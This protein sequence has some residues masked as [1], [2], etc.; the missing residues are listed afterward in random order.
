MGVEEVTF[1]LFVLYQVVYGC[2]QIGWA[3]RANR[4][5]E[6]PKDRRVEPSPSP[7]E[8]LHVTDLLISQR[9]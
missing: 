6:S 7:E 9:G 4:E 1:E 2:G 8:N 5:M 3:N